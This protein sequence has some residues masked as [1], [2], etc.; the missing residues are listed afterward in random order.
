MPSLG[1]DAVLTGAMQG[2]SRASRLPELS[3][4]GAAAI[5]IRTPRGV[6]GGGG[7]GPYI[8]PIIRTLSTKALF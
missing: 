3:G 5:I 2:S 6:G 7:R 4:G 8:L 1:R